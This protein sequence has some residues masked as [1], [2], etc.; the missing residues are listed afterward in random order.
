MT[1]TPGRAREIIRAQSQF[2]YWG[3]YS[4]FMTPEESAFVADAFKQSE[5]GNVSI[6][7]IVQRRARAD[8]WEQPP[9]FDDKDVAIARERLTEWNSRPGPRV[10][11][12]VK[13]LDGT[14]RRFT[15]DWGTDI[16]T[17]LASGVDASFYFYGSCMSFS[18]SLD[19][20]IPKASLVETA[21]IKPGNAWFFH[22]NSSGAG[23]GVYFTVPCRVFE[24]RH[25]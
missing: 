20:A 4:K 6:A 7:G 11:D 18:G 9:H 15:H 19:R 22:H 23:R 2:P 10:G 17:T 16:Q 24:V 12:W 5:S 1:L 13:M 8:M 14:L 21:E 25:V 3:N